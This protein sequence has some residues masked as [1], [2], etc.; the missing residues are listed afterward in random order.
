[1]NEKEV[2]SRGLQYRLPYLSQRRGRDCIKTQDS[3]HM[4]YMVLRLYIYEIIG[5]ANGM[6]RMS[7]WRV[8]GLEKF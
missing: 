5:D 7:I 4:L 1:M 8:Q 2:G 3:E 6:Q